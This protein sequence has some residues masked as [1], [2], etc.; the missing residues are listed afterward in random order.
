MLE[1]I[2]EKGTAIAMGILELVQ[3]GTD[4][5]PHDGACDSCWEEE[6]HH[7]LLGDHRE[8]LSPAAHG[9][10][11]LSVSGR[12]HSQEFSTHDEAEDRCVDQCFD[13]S[14][15]SARELRHAVASLQLHEKQLESP[16]GAVTCR[17]R[18][19]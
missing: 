7:D 14:S 4:E 2:E 1:R 6:G 16:A 10:S 19:G 3:Q 8:K 12:K 11:P 9:H 5:D 15:P 18:F 17:N 13:D